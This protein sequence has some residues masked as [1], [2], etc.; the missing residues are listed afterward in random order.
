M[1]SAAA[2]LACLLMARPEVIGQPAPRDDEWPRYGH[3]GSLTG[4]TALKGD[5]KAP[6]LAWS[7]FLT[8]AQVDLELRPEAGKRS[9]RLSAAEPSTVAARTAPLPGAALLDLDGSGILA[10]AV[11][12]HHERWADVLPEIKGLERISWDQTWTTEKIC[13]LELFAHDQ[14]RGRPRRVWISEAEDTIFNPLDIIEDIDRDGVQEICIALHYRVLIFEGTTG[15]KE[16]ELRF[17]NSRSYG[18]FGLAEV[19]GDADVELVI[20]SDFQSHLDVLDY[21]SGK[22][23]PERLSVKWRR[24]LETAIE[25]REKWPQVGP[26]P[27]VDFTGDGKPEIIINLYNDTGDGEWHAS[28]LEAATGKELLDLPR[29]YFQGSADL[30]GDGAAEI[31]TAET[32]GPLVLS[33]G[34]IEVAGFRKSDGKPETLWSAP[35]AAFATANLPRLDR[36][37]STTAAEGM[38]HV[39]ISAGKVH[40]AFLVLTSGPAGQSTTIAAWRH[41]G[42]HGF[43]SLWTLAGLPEKVEPLG[44]VGIAEES[45]IATVRLSIAAGGELALDADGVAPAMVARSEIGAPAIQPIAARLSP[46]GVPRVVV[47]GPAGEIFALEPPAPDGS[48][49]ARI[50]WK[51]RGR[52]MSDGSRQ[53]GFLAA[54]LDGEG[55]SEVVAA[56]AEPSGAAALAAYR[57]DGS[58][59]WRRAFP[60]TPGGPPVWN[61][62]ALTFWWPGRFRSSERVDLFVSTRRGPM[63]SDI[64]HLLDGRTG[65]ILWSRE[66]AAAPGEFS[67]GYAGSAIAAADLAGDGRDEIANLYPVCFWTADGATGDFLAARDLASRKLLPAWAAYGEPII[68]DADRDGRRDILLDSPYIL[69]MLDRDGKLLW[70]GK[71]RRDY[72]SGQASDNIGETTD[73]RHTIL[74]LDGDGRLEIASAGYAD[75]ARA[76]DAGSGKILWSVAAPRPTGRKCAAADVDGAGGEELLY[77]SGSELI[78][79]TG[80]RDSGRILWRWQGHAPLSL[81]AIADLDVDGKA[82]IILQSADGRIHCLDGPAASVEK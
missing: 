45:P 55:G 41:G 65:E 59:F 22:P 16:T 27:L 34:R 1:F 13:H 75:G 15:R 76:I 77:V 44:I 79:V 26:R 37:F 7:F 32:S 8:G 36:R 4:R 67:W 63:H 25:R 39:L 70:H 73:I 80:N 11:E 49:A 33:R 6:R 47:E 81:P 56:D 38:K 31:F 3:D 10:P 58:V 82:E 54:D 17:H 48:R 53:M 2:L 35:H 24:D 66:K 51:A 78:A 14:G 18:W 64:G 20:L 9:L 74:D 60:R 42:K 61:V 52:G 50:E 62:A 23:E 30:D 19:D 28:V 57:G 29:R 69:A 21:D 68:F 43:S 71:A 46:G 12:S 72:P 5:L 40:P